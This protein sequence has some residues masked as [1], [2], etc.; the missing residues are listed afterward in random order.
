MIPGEWLMPYWGPLVLKLK[1][2]QG[3]INK[4]LEEGNKSKEKQLDAS[5]MLAGVITGQFFY[6]HGYEQWFLPNFNNQILSQY[7]SNLSEYQP[8]TYTNKGQLKYPFNIVQSSLWINYQKSK[9]Y[10]PP[11]KHDGDLS[12]VIYLQVPDDMLDEDIKDQ[13]NIKQKRPGRINFFTDSDRPFSISNYSALPEVGDVYIFP[14]WLMHYV[15]PF[16][17]DGER[18][19]VSG[20]IYLE[21]YSSINELNQW[22]GE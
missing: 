7:E 10:N 19:S 4:L 21:S 9:E 5:D 18:I 16:E 12:F 3:F 17:S 8:I 14:S 15:N 20:N 2:E 11:H 22:K 6:E 1:I 13:K